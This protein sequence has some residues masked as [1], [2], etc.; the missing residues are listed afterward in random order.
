MLKH[1]AQIY[2]T[3]ILISTILKISWTIHTKRITTINLVLSLLVSKGF[4]NTNRYKKV[5]HNKPDIL[6]NIKMGKSLS[7]HVLWYN[8]YY[9]LTQQQR[10]KKN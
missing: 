9:L 5:E 4:F 7:Y 8:D 10:N 3:I 2:E 1:V 6:E